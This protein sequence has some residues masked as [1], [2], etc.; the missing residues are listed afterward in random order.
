MYIPIIVFKQ[1]F[2]FKIHLLVLQGMEDTEDAIVMRFPFLD[3][4]LFY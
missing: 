2:L 1:I 4:W 3:F